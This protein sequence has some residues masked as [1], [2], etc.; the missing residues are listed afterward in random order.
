MWVDE[1]LPQAYGGR[2]VLPYVTDRTVITFEPLST[3][4]LLLVTDSTFSCFCASRASVALHLPTW[5]NA[6][7]S[8]RELL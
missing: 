5:T 8:L 3:C 7:P 1:E 6:A 4:V 2:N